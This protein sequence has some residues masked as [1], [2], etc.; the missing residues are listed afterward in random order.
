MEEQ[1][2][3]C[4]AVIASK[5]ALVAGGRCALQPFLHALASTCAAARRPLP[6]KKRRPF[7][8]AT[9]NLQ[10]RLL[11]SVPKARPSRSESSE[12]R[13]ALRSKDD[14]YVRLLKRQAA[15]ID[16]LLVR[17]HNA[18]I[19]ACVLLRYIVVARAAA[20]MQPRMPL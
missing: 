2:A 5:D 19:Q 14:E 4:E 17:Q 16:T 9:C 20:C 1:R 10:Q 13:G 18:L 6:A 11:I 15:E 12:L 7:A 3:A 8:P